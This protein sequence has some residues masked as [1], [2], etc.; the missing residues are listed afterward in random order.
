MKSI[1]TYLNEDA[2]LRRE[3]NELIKKYLGSYA[4]EVKVLRVFNRQRMGEKLKINFYRY[5][6]KNKADISK[7]YSLL[8][9]LL[10]NMDDTLPDKIKGKYN[11]VKLNKDISK[12]DYVKSK[13]KDY[14]EY[15]E[16]VK[17]EAENGPEILKQIAVE[18]VKSGKIYYPITFDLH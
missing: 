18:K 5:N 17:Q 12:E 7:F 2:D 8:Y 9:D 16:W 1:I 6:A 14:D 4:S 11:Y 13:E 15:C 10:K 3:E